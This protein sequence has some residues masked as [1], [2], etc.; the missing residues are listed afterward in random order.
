MLCSCDAIEYLANF[1]RGI[2]DK[3]GRKGFENKGGKMSILTVET[4]MNFHSNIGI[5]PGFYFYKIFENLHDM[6]EHSTRWMRVISDKEDVGEFIVTEV[7]IVANHPSR[8]SE[9]TPFLW[10]NGDNCSCLRFALWFD[11]PKTG[12]GVMVSIDDESLVITLTLLP[13]DSDAMMFIELTRGVIEA[14][15]EEKRAS[16]GL[17]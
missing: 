2:M 3:E 17:K 12:N 14:M 16:Y 1:V 8:Q 11:D 13:D 6:R 15:L 10:L 7:S 4:D 5:G 9:G